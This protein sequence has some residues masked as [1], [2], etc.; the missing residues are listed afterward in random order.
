MLCQGIPAL[1]KRRQ[2]NNRD[3]VMLRILH[4]ADWQIG[5]VFGDFP[6]E[7]ATVLRR[8]RLQ[9]VETLARLAA[10]RDLDAVLVAGDVFETNGV[11]DETLRRTLE[12]MR[13][14]RGPWVLLPGNHDAALAESA[15]SRLQRLGVPANVRLALTEAPILLADGRLAVLP[16]PLLRRHE[17]RDLTEVFDRLET[18]PEAVRVGL[19]HGSVENR[20][21]EAAESYNLISD[22]RADSARLDYLALGDWHGSLEVA[23]RSWYAGTPETDRFK[24]NNSGNALIVTLPGPGQTPQV[25]VVASGHYRWHQLQA[26][27]S[28]EAGL[29][30]L[31]ASL[32]GLGEPYDQRVVALTLQ[33]T[34]SLE[35]RRR[36]DEL[37][38][39]W[40]ARVLYL[41]V[42]DRE[43]LA[44]A[45]DA[46]LEQLDDGG[47]VQAA[48]S[49]LRAIQSQEGHAEQTHAAAALQRLYREYLKLR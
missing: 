42:Q 2:Y 32:I 17:L 33:G 46:D 39:Q 16:A 8:Q 30:A 9:T 18:P 44:A 12:A 20:L 40:G 28:D 21:P 10:E 31:E 19:A 37:L 35:Q 22:R 45:S 36:L 3:R 5:K 48:V 4:T 23:P 27:V 25:E 38:Q 34:V 6:E 29:A 43:L 14:F 49:R 1:P 11:A 26:T 47:L 13:H 7:P 15:W 24:T 41:R